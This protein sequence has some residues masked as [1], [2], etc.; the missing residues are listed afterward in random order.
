MTGA[1]APM[2]RCKFKDESDKNCLQC[3][4]RLMMLT[5]PRANGPGPGSASHPGP[6]ISL[7]ATPPKQLFSGIIDL[8]PAKA[9]GLN[10][11]EGRPRAKDP[12]DRPKASPWVLQAWN[13]CTSENGPRS[14]RRPRPQAPAK[15]TGLR[16]GSCSSFN[17]KCFKFLRSDICTIEVEYSKFKKININK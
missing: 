9:E 11:S 14:L 12:Q 4:S 15:P 10:T 6:K 17:N 13:E 8:T 1:D 2:Y 7:R 5:C 16:C 3:T